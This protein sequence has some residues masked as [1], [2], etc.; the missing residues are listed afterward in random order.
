MAQPEGGTAQ[1]EGSSSAQPEGGAAPTGQLTS[2]ELQGLLRD[3]QLAGSWTLD[4]ARSKVRLK[5]RHTWGLLP[6]NGVFHQVSG[7]GTVAPDGTVTG[8][9]TVAAESVDTRNK[10]RDKHLRSADFFHV[11]NHPEFTFAVDDV[12]LTDRSVRVNGRLTVRGNTRPASFDATVSRADGEVSLDGELPVDRTDFGLTW[13]F[14]GIA[15]VRNTIVVHAVFT[16]A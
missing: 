11:E 9:I 7:N 15:S 5:T 4:P 8:V 1:P 14:M 13:N 2:T 10:Q 6:L 12:T 16:R 3:G